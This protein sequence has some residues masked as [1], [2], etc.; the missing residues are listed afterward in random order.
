[1]CDALVFHRRRVNSD[2]EET[3]IKRSQCSSVG[4]YC[5]ISICQLFFL[6]QLLYC[7]GLQMES[8]S[9]AKSGI[10]TVSTH[11]LSVH[12]YALSGLNKLI[13]E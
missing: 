6:C 1:M 7:R 13:N 8:S 9:S 12:Q 2:S 10:F 3:L 11:V 5:R 4:L